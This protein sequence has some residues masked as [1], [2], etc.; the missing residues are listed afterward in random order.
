MS[1]LYDA[2]IL[3]DR[4][5]NMADAVREAVERAQWPLSER[6]AA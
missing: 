1:D 6:E 4:G 3:V 5:I 2:D